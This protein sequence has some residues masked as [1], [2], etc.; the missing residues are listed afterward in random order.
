VRLG[1]RLTRL[2]ARPHLP[3]RTVR[4]RL[5][6]LYG[7]LFLASGAALLATTYVLVRHNTSGFIFESDDGT[8]SAV[9]ESNDA[10]AGPPRVEGE[11]SLSPSGS[12]K[13]TPEQAEAQARQADAQARA[14]HESVLRQ[15]L[16][17]SGIAL[18]GMSIL[19]IALG[20]IVAGRVLRPVR[21]I[22]TTARD[23]SAT[24]LHERLALGG[25]DDELKELG[26]TFDDL[27]ARLEASF[28]SQRQFVANA[29]HELRTP[30]ARQRTVAQVAL[31]DPDATVESLRAAH[32]R[33]LAS[34]AQQERLIEALLTLTRGQTGLDRREPFDLATVTDQVLLARQPEAERRGLDIH[35]ALSAA[36]AD[37]A[38]RLAERLVVNLVDNALRHNVPDGR[39]EVAT[40]T[41]A[42]HAVLSVVNTGRVVPV[43]AV[44]RLFQPFQRL[45]TDRIGHRDGLGLGL[46]IVQAI[47]TAHDATVVVQPRPEGGLH[48]EVS[49]PTPSRR[50]DGPASSLDDG[51]GDG[52]P[53]AA[54]EN[55]AGGGGGQWHADDR[56]CEVE[57]RGRPGPTRAQGSRPSR[58]RHPHG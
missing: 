28:R 32:E 15:L 55:P 56:E 19:S 43:T 45:A 37:G 39:I 16:I 53:L 6:L 29:S 9:I 26:D 25:P 48:V 46:S 31:A 20:W 17:Q 33:V 5:T 10:P 49:F 38:P 42:G 3:R 47:A 57:D 13:L 8:S 54:G 11:Q 24:N 18:A 44:D 51:P 12:A 35:A 22:T 52:G 36:P 4:L 58:F 34:G 7:G 2:A 14:E 50:P 30:L 41:R 23:I 27:L 1:H 40:E 21:T